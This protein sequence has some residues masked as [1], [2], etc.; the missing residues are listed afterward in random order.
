L[1]V[2]IPPLQIRNRVAPAVNQ[3]NRFNQEV[4]V[5]ECTGTPKLIAPAED[6]ADKILA[7]SG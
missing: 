7:L 4:E 2:T 1:L 5:V 6:F 3:A